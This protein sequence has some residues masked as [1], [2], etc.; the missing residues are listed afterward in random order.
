MLGLD[1]YLDE[2]REK[3][4]YLR[5]NSCNISFAQRYFSKELGNIDT[6]KNK[7]NGKHYMLLHIKINGVA[8]YIFYLDD[9][10]KAYKFR[11]NDYYKIIN[12]DE[13]EH[14]EIN[15]ANYLLICNYM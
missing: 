7:I 5:C 8:R 2:K 15:N 1:N 13:F 3:F 4:K 9:Y 14:Y 11:L 6:L 10:Y 12:N